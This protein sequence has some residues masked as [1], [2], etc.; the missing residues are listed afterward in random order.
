MQ[1]NKKNKTAYMLLIWQICAALYLGG[2]S[3]SGNSKMYL[4]AQTQDGR[5]AEDAQG[6]PQPASGPDKKKEESGLEA[7]SAQQEHSGTDFETASCFVYVCGAVKHPG[8]FE[9][10]Q[11]SRIYEAIA[12]AGGLQKNAS[13]K[14]IN[15][16]QPVS[17]GDMIEILTQK[18]Y[19]EQESRTQAGQH[20]K[21]GPSGSGVQDISG[22]DGRIDINTASA[23]QLMTLKGIGAAKAANIIAYRESSGKFQAPEDIMN[24]DGIGEGVYA[25]IQDKIKV[26]Q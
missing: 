16:A 23:E 17:D 24:V 6:M 12:L 14:G 15:Q 9:L 5:N 26:I 19:E 13:V 18:E 1:M 2:C 25:G 8:V 21:E 3:G 20:P 4:Q 10:P 22:E 11:G 7:E